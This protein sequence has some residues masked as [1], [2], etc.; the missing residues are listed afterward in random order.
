MLGNIYQK[1][2]WT[3]KAVEQ[4]REFLAMWKDADPGLPELIDAKKRFA[5]LV[6]R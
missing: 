4:Y 1:K 6:N 3:A 5:E 2:G